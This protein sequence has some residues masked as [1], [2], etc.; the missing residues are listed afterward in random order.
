MADTIGW[1]ATAVFSA[2]YFFRSAAAL[3]RVQA[4]AA[5]LWIGY[6]ITISSKPVI[7]ANLIVAAGAVLTTLR[8]RRP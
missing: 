2:S 4:A 3:R 6:G 1:I 8:P 7:G 5:C